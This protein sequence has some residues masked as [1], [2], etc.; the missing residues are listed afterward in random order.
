LQLRA[1]ERGRE[2]S[3][4][5]GGVVNFRLRENIVAGGAES[6]SSRSPMVVDIQNMLRSLETKTARAAGA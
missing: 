3:D 5:K 6:G 1:E 2:E 4:E